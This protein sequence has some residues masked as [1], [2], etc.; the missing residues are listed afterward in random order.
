MEEKQLNFNQIC[1]LDKDLDKI[2]M[3]MI[4]W[5]KN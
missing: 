5:S 3:E 2:Y 1:E 4:E